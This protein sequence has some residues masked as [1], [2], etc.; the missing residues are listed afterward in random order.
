MLTGYRGKVKITIYM[1]LH[2]QFIP[3]TFVLSMEQ[4]MKAILKIK[5]QATLSFPKGQACYMLSVPFRMCC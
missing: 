1:V 5:K 2:K 3:L 4:I